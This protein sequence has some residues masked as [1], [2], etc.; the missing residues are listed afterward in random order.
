MGG[1]GEEIEGSLARDAVFFEKNFH[2]A[3]LGG[4][5]TGKIDYDRGENF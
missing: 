5:I 4:W 2:V 3:G 1:A